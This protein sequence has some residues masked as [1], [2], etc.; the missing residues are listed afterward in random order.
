MSA[1][2]LDAK[3]AAP[4]AAGGRDSRRFACLECGEACASTAANA[5]FCSTNCRKAWNNRRAMRGAELYDLV[6]V[7]RFD[8]AR[9]KALRI[10]TLLCRMAALFREDDWNARGG[11][12]SWSPA[13]QVLERKAYLHA[14]VVH[15]GRRG[16]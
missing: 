4:A 2:R 9:C 6:M 15:R 14:V 11:R 3:L 13:E 16:R 1:S 5:E 8:R 12:R 10:W 7:W